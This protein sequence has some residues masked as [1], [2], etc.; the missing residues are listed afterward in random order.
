MGI[1]VSLFVQY[2]SVIVMVDCQGC[3][4]AL[5]LPSDV[6]L[7]PKCA[8]HARYRDRQQEDGWFATI[9]ETHKMYMHEK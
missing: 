9:D 2:M 3:C 4:S 8:G 7:K 1:C 6:V 5:L